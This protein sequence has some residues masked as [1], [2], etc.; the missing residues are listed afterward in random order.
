MDEAVGEDHAADRSHARR[1]DR[2]KVGSRGLQLER[3][4]VFWLGALGLAL[5]AVVI[6]CLAVFLLARWFR[7]ALPG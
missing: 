5:L 2:M 6:T 4:D 1:H 7:V 3:S